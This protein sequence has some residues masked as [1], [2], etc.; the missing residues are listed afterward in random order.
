MGILNKCDTK[1]Y[2]TKMKNK[3][4]KEISEIRTRLQGCQDFQVF[5]CRNCKDLQCLTGY[6]RF[7]YKMS[8]F[9]SFYCR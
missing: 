5:F 1:F 6:S 7:N 2:T 4:H 9:A 3:H 8:G